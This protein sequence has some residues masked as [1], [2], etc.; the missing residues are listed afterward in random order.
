MLNTATQARTMTAPPVAAG[1]RPDGSEART[2]RRARAQ[3]PARLITATGEVVS[4]MVCDVSEGG[5][6]LMSSVNM[7]VGTLVDIALAVPRLGDASRSV[8]VRCKVRVVFCAFVGEQSRMG[9][10]FTALPM[11]AR[12]AIRSYVIARS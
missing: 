1:F 12:M 7:P 10:Q 5:V 4:G 9:V 8:P 3:W 11:S 2:H 6:G